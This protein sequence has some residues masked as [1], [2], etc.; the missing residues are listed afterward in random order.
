MNLSKEIELVFSALNAL[1]TIDNKTLKKNKML[2]RDI[3]QALSPERI[4]SLVGNLSATIKDNQFAKEQEKEFNHD[5]Y[6]GS[7]VNYQNLLTKQLDKTASK[8][9]TK[10][11]SQRMEIAYNSKPKE[12]KLDSDT[13]QARKKMAK[14]SLYGNKSLQINT[15]NDPTLLSSFIDY[16]PYTQNYYDYLS[17]P[18]L[19]VLIDRPISLAF[20]F[21]AE[22]DFDNDKL[23]PLFKKIMTRSK[24][25]ESIKNLIFN[26]SLSPRGALLLPIIQH[27]T[28]EVRFSALNDTQFTYAARQP[29][30]FDDLYTTQSGTQVLTG[31]YALGG[32]FQ[33]DV[34][35]HFLCPGFEPL[36]GVGKNK[37][38]QLR[39]A[40]QIMNIYV[41]IMKVL[42]I[43]AQILVQKWNGSG[44][45]DAMLSAMK[46]LQ[47][48]INSS[49]SLSEVVPVSDDMSLEI[50]NNNFTP[51]YADAAP[52]IKS[53]I[54][55]ISGVMPDILFGSETAYNAN[56][57]NINITNQNIHSDFQK[58]QIEPALRFAIN[59]LLKYDSRLVKYKDQ[60]DQFDMVFPSLYERTENEKLTDQSLE[61]DNIQKM[62]DYP[63]YENMYKKLGLLDKDIDLQKE[64][65]FN[66]KNLD[67]LRS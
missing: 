43:R 5:T 7:Y 40:A 33:N 60:V 19:D 26:S 31:I 42:A 8:R 35:A 12:T 64:L 48:K 2:R 34:T 58:Q 9:F 59:F 41:Y 55:A 62:A 17:I 54:G 14:N 46:R 51:G 47:A 32:K 29:R 1:S 56:S 50:L 36:Y 39:E 37:T 25:Y 11:A 24:L 15:P 28:G 20:K 45:S 52:V 61:I 65:K 66:D 44:E 30:S 27:H 23:E 57:F 16:S 22:I 67:D 6:L 4:D 10:P 18:I 63:Q 3:M 38:R 13:E 53:Y 49:L 21:P